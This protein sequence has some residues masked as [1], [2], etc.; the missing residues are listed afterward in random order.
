MPAIESPFDLLLGAYFGEDWEYDGD[1][2][3]A[4]LRVFCRGEPPGLVA[5]A[6]A[7]A[8]ALLAASLDEKRLERELH[9]R[10]LIYNPGNEG[11]THRQWLELVVRTLGSSDCRRSWRGPMS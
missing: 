1:S 3:E 11:R 6:R 5:E 8:E 10:G 2:A 7:E 4:V 9:R